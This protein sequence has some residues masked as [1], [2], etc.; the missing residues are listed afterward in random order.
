MYLVDED[1]CTACGIC[2]DFCPAGAITL[3]GRTAEIDQSRCDACGSCSVACERGAIYEVL[4]PAPARLPAGTAPL[5]PAPGAAPALRRRPYP[6]KRQQRAAALAV[7]LPTLSRL[8]L[9]IVNRYL[10]HRS[11]SPYRGGGARL[12]DLAPAKGG[13]GRHRWRGGP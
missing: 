3:R 2:L 13:Q 1:E 12:D 10:D 6:A 8:V 11:R 5:S 4:E 9:E 7:A